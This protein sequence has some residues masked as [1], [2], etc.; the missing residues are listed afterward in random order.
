MEAITLIGVEIIEFMEQIASIT[1]DKIRK[2]MQKEDVWLTQKQASEYCRVTPQTI[3]NLEKKGDVVFKRK[4][5]TAKYLKSSLEPFI[6][7]TT[8]RK[9]A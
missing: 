6:K 3:Y 1:A 9:V 8:S 5:S 2:Q 7:K 4:N